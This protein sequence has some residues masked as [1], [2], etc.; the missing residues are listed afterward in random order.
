MQSTEDNFYKAPEANLVGN[1]EGE[2]PILKFNRFTTWGVLGLSVITLGFYNYYWLI[3]RTK[4]ANLVSENKM[5]QMPVY[6]SLALGIASGIVTYGGTTPQL[7]LASGGMS[8]L[9]GCFLL[10]SIFA[11]RNKLVEITNRG[12]SNPEKMGGIKTFFL[13][14]FFLNYRINKN[15]DL[16]LGIASAIDNLSVEAKKTA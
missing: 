2:H 3:S 7:Q 10:Y 12:S 4:T 11:L 9:S 5:S 14:V 15:I 6:L 8:L 1:V 13:N 16:Q